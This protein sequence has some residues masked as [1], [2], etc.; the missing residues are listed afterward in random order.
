MSTAPKVTLTIVPSGNENVPTFL[1]TCPF[2][3]KQIVAEIR[4]CHGV[5]NTKTCEC[6]R[7][8]LAVSRT[9]SD[10]ILR[11]RLANLFARSGVTITIFGDT[12]RATNCSWASL[13]FALA[14]THEPA[15]AGKG[16][17]G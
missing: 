10:N 6:G 4:H 7:A 8:M 2:C 5:S 1:A 17:S 15:D 3:G 9:E 14:W 12:V 13:S 11:S 16:T